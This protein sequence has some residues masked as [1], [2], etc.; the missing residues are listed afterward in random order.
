MYDNDRFGLSLALLWCT[1]QKRTMSRTSNIDLEACWK[2]LGREMFRECNRMNHH[3]R[4]PAGEARF[5][6]L[7]K[8]TMV[9]ST[10]EFPRLVI[11][12]G[13]SMPA[14]AA[15]VCFATNFYADE[16]SPPEEY[17]LTI[18]KHMACNLG[19]TG[20]KVSV[21][22]MCRRFFDVLCAASSKQ[23]LVP[24]AS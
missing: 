13:A 19:K 14:E 18:D 6:W 8:H 15:M 9:A 17:V 23:K 5:T 21:R 3:F 22:E 16:T 7:T 10:N 20:E 4:C 1:T 2:A 24:S 11:T 12:K